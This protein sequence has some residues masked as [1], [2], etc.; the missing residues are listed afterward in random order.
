MGKILRQPP[1]EVLLID[2]QGNQ[3]QGQ[4]EKYLSE[5]EPKETGGT[6]VRWE[7]E[8]KKKDIR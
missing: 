5:E 7:P 1:T 4:S 3:K 2:C 8:T 6:N